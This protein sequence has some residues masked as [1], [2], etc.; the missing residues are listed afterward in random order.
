M[1]KLPAIPQRRPFL[2]WRLASSLGEAKSEEAS[3]EAA[4]LEALYPEPVHRM[5]QDP[6][7]AVHRQ[8]RK[9]RRQGE[10]PSCA[11]ERSEYQE[12]NNCDQTC[13][14]AQSADREAWVVD[15]LDFKVDVLR[16]THLSRQFKS[17]SKPVAIAIATRR[18]DRTLRPI[19]LSSAVG[20]SLRGKLPE[21]NA[22]P[23]QHW[24]RWRP[25]CW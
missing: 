13:W 24:P 7:N 3:P 21:R 8:Q 1:R 19:T 10:P 11:A 14:L 22:V 4:K 23:Y 15:R 9:K 16:Q 25:D 12:K 2:F 5:R 18:I 17:M 20:L 6:I